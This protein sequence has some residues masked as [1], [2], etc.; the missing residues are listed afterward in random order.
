[1]KRTKRPGMHETHLVHAVALSEQSMLS[2]GGP[3]GAVVI[4]NGKVIGTGMNS[5]HILNDPTAHAEVLAIR[6]ACERL[7]SPHLT[8]CILYASCEPCP[9]CISAIYWA[10]IKEVYFAS[11]KKDAAVAGFTE[12]DETARIT[13]E[14][15]LSPEHRSIPFHYVA[16]SDALRVFRTRA[17][18]S[19]TQH[20]YDRIGLGYLTEQKRFYKEKADPTRAF[21]HSHL[22]ANLSKRLV[23]VGCG[24]GSDLQEY[25]SLGF[26]NAI[27]IDPSSVMVTET[28]KLLGAS[29]AE[30]GS[31]TNLP[32]T[33]NSINYLIGRF[34][35]HYV[36]DIDAAYR[37]AA[38]VLKKN[39]TI[40]VIIPNMTVSVGEK[41]LTTSSRTH[42]RVPL[43]GGKVSVTYPHR[44]PKEFD[45]QVFR[46][47]F[48]VVEKKHLSGGGAD[49]SGEC[50]VLGVVAHKK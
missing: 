24:G 28:H 39:G 16:D 44:T 40:I 5:V 22:T 26:K 33:S 38:R 12:A 15:S 36:E 46:E 34:S 19:D 18:R 4:R 11:T 37:E 43:Y 27:G 47:L 14:I 45:T 35:L 6:E 41:A 42:L 31:W 20:Q 7:G 49:A 32:F 50:D 25:R 9:L 8:D 2:G 3:F 13:K 10:Q 23:D 17:A 21:I 30:I 1:M 29:S 48:T